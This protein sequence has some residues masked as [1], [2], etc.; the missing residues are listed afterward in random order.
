MVK[1]YSEDLRIK[2]VT[3]KTKESRLFWFIQIKQ[4]N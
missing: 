4:S 1:A 3:E 2:V